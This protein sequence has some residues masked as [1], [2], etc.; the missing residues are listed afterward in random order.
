MYATIEETK[1]APVEQPMLRIEGQ[2]AWI[3]PQDSIVEGINAAKAVFESHHADPMA[4]NQ[5]NLKFI[6]GKELLSK[7]EAML[8][9]IWEEADH[10]AF[11]A[12]TIGWLSRNVD[13]Q[14]TIR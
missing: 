11:H 4:C 5:A 8:S 10:A 1:A 14:L 7:E 12:I 6:R 9:L 3:A 2:D 13:I